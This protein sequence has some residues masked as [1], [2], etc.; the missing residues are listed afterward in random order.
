MI[1]SSDDYFQDD[2]VQTADDDDDDEDEDEVKTCFFI[3]AQSRHYVTGCSHV[4][5]VYSSL[6][7]MIIKIMT[8]L[9]IKR[10]IVS[11]SP[12]KAMKASK[13]QDIL[14]GFNSFV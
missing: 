13:V 12:Q 1:G 5:C 8:I 2:R 3:C 4:V 11:V 14:N 10:K 7:I 6:V 9:T